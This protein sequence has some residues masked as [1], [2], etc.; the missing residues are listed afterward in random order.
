MIQAIVRKGKVFGEDIPAPLVSK[1]SLLIKVVNSCISAGTEISGVQGS[2]KSLVRRALDQPQHVKKLIDMVRSDGIAKAY[3]KVKGKLESATPTGYSISG[4]VIA[5]G[6]GVSRFAVGDHVAAAGAGL[7]N[8]AEYVDVPENLVMKMP[9]GMDFETASTVTLGGI[10]LQGVRRA[11]MRLGEMAV[12]VGAGI[13]GLLT[14]QMLRHSGVRVAAIDLDA[15]RLSIAKELGAELILNPA[16]ENAVSAIQNWSGGYGADAVIFT[17]ATGSSEPLS[18]S[19]QMSKR[20]GRVVLVG[21]VGMEI[22]REDIY[23]KELDFLVSTSYGPGRYDKNYEEQGLDYPYAYVRWT[24]NRNMSEYLRLL[25]DGA[26]KL[27]RL[28]NSTFT[29]DKVSEAFESLQQPGNKPLMVLLDYGIADSELFPLYCGHSR[30][31]STS[32]SQASRDIINIALVGAGGFATGMHLPNMEKLSNKYRLHCVVNRTGHK[33]KAVAEQYKAS[34]ATTDFQ[35]VL[36]DKDVDLVLIATRHDSH[37]DLA[38]QA[39]RAGKHVFVEKPLA[40][41]QKDLDAIKEF[42]ADGCAGKPVL[43]TGFNRR[44]SKYAQ[45][46]R[47]HTEK[48]VNPLL[49]HYRMNAGFIPFDNWV[50]EDGGRIIGECCHLIDL[51]TFLTGSRI[52]SISVDS[53]MPA[54][55]SYSASD[56]KAITLGY[57]DGSIATIHYFAIGS[58]D[59]PKEGMEIHFDGKSIIL[60]DYKSLKGFGLKLADISTATSQKGQLE[61]LEILYGALQ[62]KTNNWPIELWDM[63]QTTEATIEIAKYEK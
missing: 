1:G 36:N 7:A 62:G 48:R 32:I 9:V 27:D 2:G 59:L 30:K 60:D 42:Y 16:D 13:L 45:E 20:K 23:Q 28:I 54:N 56:N 26:I 18:Q 35:D 52:K 5:I 41:N 25:H 8:H 4:V 39:L 10:A 19:F 11:D 37:A 34:Y 12:V 51:M 49:I 15:S 40:T 63:I 14:I 46:I 33:A 17:A 55:D 21:V 31:V 43:F 61:E 50:H 38:L 24:E 47:K 22:K 53:L 3:A 29:I 44:F 57:H 6:D 58:R